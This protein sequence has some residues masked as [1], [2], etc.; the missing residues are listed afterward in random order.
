MATH[1]IEKAEKTYGGFI[2]TLKWSVPLI[3]LITLFVVM[4]IAE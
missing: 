2:A 3:A 1:D 4:L